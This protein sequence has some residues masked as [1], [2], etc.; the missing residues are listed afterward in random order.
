VFVESPIAAATPLVDRPST[1]SA[2]SSSSRPASAAA[3]ATHGPP[4]SAGTP[5][6]LRV[7]RRTRVR[8]VLVEM[9]MSAAM[10]R[11]ECPAVRRASSSRSRPVSA[12]TTAR[13]ASSVSGG[14]L[15]IAAS[16][17]GGG[18]RTS[19]VSTPAGP[20]ASGGQDMQ[21]RAASAPATGGL[22]RPC[23]ARPCGAR[24]LRTGRCA[25]GMPGGDLAVGI[26]L[27]SDVTDDVLAH[28]Q[29]QGGAGGHPARP[30]SRRGARPGRG[31]LQRLAHRRDAQR[32]RH[33]PAGRAPC[34]PCAPVHRRT[35]VRGSAA[36]PRCTAWVIPGGR[37]PGQH[38]RPGRWTAPLS[39][40]PSG[41]SRP[42][43]RRPADAKR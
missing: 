29:A 20:A 31:A 13:Q 21:C 9:P 27:A 4:S 30:R 8:T 3:T 38:G 19:D 12:G 34:R 26:A 37:S 22:G 1:S 41:S 15:G 11:T 17:A 2:S 23:G 32:P 18:P 40:T 16:S 28:V 35:G 25:A 14:S 5:P 33:D 39:A 6:S 42:R 10:R 24:P 43:P 7:S 36:R